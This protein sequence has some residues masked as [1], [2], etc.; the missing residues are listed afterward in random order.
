MFKHSRLLDEFVEGL[1]AT[2]L[3]PLL[4]AFPT[5][6]Q[7]LFTFTELTSKEVQ[8]SLVLPNEESF[9]AQE[10]TILHYLRKYIDE[11]DSEGIEK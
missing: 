3:Y 11:C 10:S 5:L 9:I 6:F 8:N 2:S 1:K 4:R 7:P